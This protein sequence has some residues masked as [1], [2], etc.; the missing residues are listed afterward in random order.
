MSII[1]D[2]TSEVKSNNDLKNAILSGNVNRIVKLPY[3]ESILDILYDPTKNM[4]HIITLIH[5][6]FSKLWLK[7]EYISDERIFYLIEAHQGNA[8]C[9]KLFETLIDNI[10]ADRWKNIRRDYDRS[11]I[12]HV[13]ITSNL[14]DK[15]ISKYLRIFVEIG[16][17][18]NIKNNIG[19][20]MVCA[21]ELAKPKI[22]KL[23]VN[24]YKMNVNDHRIYNGIDLQHAYL[25]LFVILKNYAYEKNQNKLGDIKESIKLLIKNNTKLNYRIPDIPGIIEGQGC[26]IHDYIAYYGWS[27]LLRDIFYQHLISYSDCIPVI[28]KEEYVVKPVPFINILYN[29][30]PN[31]LKNSMSQNKFYEAHQIDIDILADMV[32]GLEKYA[33]CKNKDLVTLACNKIIQTVKN[34]NKK[35]ISKYH[36]TEILK[37]YYNNLYGFCDI[38]SVKHAFID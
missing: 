14:P 10:P 26:S 19:T 18:I 11:S 15:Y 16:V 32:N 22:I 31:D 9:D 7:Q 24:E 29:S 5:K 3:V 1:L 30:L 38:D 37:N 23:L 20:I 28:K 8:H 35:Y 4:Y 2:N 33:F 6:L 36:I 25:P 12:L 21:A 34:I 27:D 17:D 13:I